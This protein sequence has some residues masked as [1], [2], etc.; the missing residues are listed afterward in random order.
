MMIKDTSTHDIWFELTT[1]QP[2]FDDT[3]MRN[4]PSVFAIHPTFVRT[5]MTETFAA[6]PEDE[7]WN[8]GGFRR[9]LAAGRGAAPERAADLV[10]L[11]A[12]GMADALSGCFITVRDDVADMVAR[13]EEIEQNELY[14]LRLR[15]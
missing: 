9:A 11:L 1:V 14:T 8:E 15:T 5:A 3:R 12:S 7:E 2:Y 13:A 10:V 6:S 4:R